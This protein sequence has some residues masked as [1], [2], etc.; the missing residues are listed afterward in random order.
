M[1]V[2]VKWLVTL[3][4][5]VRFLSGVNQRVFVQI[6]FLTERLVTLWAVVLLDPTVGLLVVRKSLSAWKCSGT[7]C[8]RHLFCHLQS[9]LS[10]P[11]WVLKLTDWQNVKTILSTDHSHFLLAPS[12][13]CVLYLPDWKVEK[14]IKK[15]LT[16][17]H[18]HFRKHWN[19][20]NPRPKL[21]PLILWHN[22]VL[23][24]YLWW[25]SHSEHLKKKYKTRNTHSDTALDGKNTR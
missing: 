5:L 25:I 13:Y 8:A 12:E 22:N 4:A 1:N 15:I 24:I 20:F 18:S 3:C 21:L 23:M 14:T 16:T 17:D 10:C 9:T 6:A 2:L 7:Q 11:F 19:D